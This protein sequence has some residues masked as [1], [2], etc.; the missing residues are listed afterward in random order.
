MGV[1]E[2]ERRKVDV[3]MRGRT[4]RWT[5]VRGEGPEEV[6]RKDRIIEETRSSVFVLLLRWLMVVGTI[7][8]SPCFFKFFTKNRLKTEQ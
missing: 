2:S 8:L 6:V 7:L 5:D 1:G 3:R 4:H